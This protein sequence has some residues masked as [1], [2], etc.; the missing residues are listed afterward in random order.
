MVGAIFMILGKIYLRGS[1]PKNLRESARNF[2]N[3][4]RRFSQIKAQIPANVY[5]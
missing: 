4:S 5:L 2:G 3:V 1:A